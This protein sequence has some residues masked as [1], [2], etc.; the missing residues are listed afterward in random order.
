MDAPHMHGAGRG[1][2]NFDGRTIRQG[3]QR[4]FPE[5]CREGREAAIMIRKAKNRADQREEK[6]TGILPPGLAQGKGP[7]QAAS[8]CPKKL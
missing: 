5:K 8:S 2:E 7:A 6:E 1:C 4:D 3:R